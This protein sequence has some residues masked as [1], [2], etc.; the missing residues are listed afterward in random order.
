MRPARAVAAAKVNLA[1]V[2]GE[3]RDDGLH[4]RRPCS[5]AS[6]LRPHRARSRRAGSPSKA[7]R[8]TRSSARARGTRARGVCESRLARADTKEIPVAAAWAVKRRCSRSPRLAN[9]SLE[10]PLAGERLHGLAAQLGAD[11]PFFLEPA[12][13]LAEGAGEQ[14]ASLDIPQDFWGCS[15]PA[16]RDQPSTARSMRAS[17]AGS[18]AG[19][20]SGEPGFF[21][22][23]DVRRPRDLPRFRPTTFGAFGGCRWPR[24]RAPEPSGPTLAAPARR[25]TA[26]S[27]AARTHRP[28]PAESGD[29][30]GPGWSHPFGN[31]VAHGDDACHRGPRERLRAV[32][33]GPQASACAVHRPRGE[34]RRSARRSRMVLRPRGRRLDDRPLHLRRAADGLALLREIL[35][36]AAASQLIA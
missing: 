2:V 35:W 34:P 20:R 23:R 28:Q 14:L 13:R 36:I 31:F 12:P 21:R 8:T 17:T 11:V 33:R 19:S 30:P 1:L 27:A 24:L 26:S 18:G 10:Q 32:A 29:A 15:P 9:A 22:A 7:S 25:S 5:S 6:T 3:R 4:E 16:G